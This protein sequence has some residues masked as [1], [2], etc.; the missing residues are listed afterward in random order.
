MPVRA[1]WFDRGRLHLLDQRE[2]PGRVVVRHLRTVEQV[3]EAIRT[4]TVRGA[5]A[6]GVA[7]AY[8]MV[9]ADA[10]KRHTAA[11]AARLLRKT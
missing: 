5:P 2:L 6:I 7:A 8:G 1:L 11:T 4:L 9:L 10:G 3:A